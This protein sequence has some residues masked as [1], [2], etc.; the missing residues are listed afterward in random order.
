MLASL[1]PLSMNTAPLPRAGEGSFPV[2]ILEVAGERALVLA[3]GRILEV[4]SEI[5]LASGQEFLVTQEQR[6]DGTTAWRILKEIPPPGGSTGYSMTGRFPGNPQNEDLC[7]AL[8][9]FGVP[10]T[11]SNL[12]KAG[13]FLREMGNYSPAGTLAAA[14]SIK[15]GLE[16]ASFLQAMS[17]FFSCR[18]AGRDLTKKRAKD[19]SPGKLSSASGE[20]FLSPTGAAVLGARLKE[21]YEAMSKLF[22]TLRE[23]PGQNPEATVFPGREELGRILLAGQLFAQLRENGMDGAFYFIPLFLVT[24][25]DLFSNGE[26]L[27]YPC[28]PESGGSGSCRVLLLLETEKLGK[29][30]IDITCREK[31][32]WMEAVVEKEE[33]KLLFDRYWQELALILQ[34][35]NYQVHWSGCRVGVLSREKSGMGP[36]HSLDLLV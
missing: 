2:R 36:C 31:F 12:Q 17:S 4:R 9:R 30:Q 33:T 19:S 26:L 11:E 15:L 23:H 5:S 3:G 21:I 34:Q 13:Q 10:L 7:C 16:S 29:M 22:G 35:R 28:P 25:G 32:L 6:R 27:I 14:V 20:E 1:Q 8:R 18:L 24:G